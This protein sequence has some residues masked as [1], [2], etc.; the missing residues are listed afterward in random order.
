MSYHRYTD[1]IDLYHAQTQHYTIFFFFSGVSCTTTLDGFG[2]CHCM[3]T[4][5]K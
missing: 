4:N 2:S 3:Y 5:V 1:L